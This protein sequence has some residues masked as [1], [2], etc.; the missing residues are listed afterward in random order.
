MN[1][2]GCVDVLNACVI[3]C[4]C[5]SECMSVCIAKW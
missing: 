5:V 2:Y 4:M 3:M 1:V